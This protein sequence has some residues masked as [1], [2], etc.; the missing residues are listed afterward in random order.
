MFLQFSHEALA[1]AHH[2]SVSL[3]FRI[4]V[5][6]T[7]TTTDRKASQDVF[8][9]LF[10]AEEFQNPLVNCWVETKSAFVRTDSRVEL[11][12]VT[13]VYLNLSITVNPRNTEANHAFWLSNASQNIFFDV[14][15]MFFKYRFQSAKELFNSLKEFRFMAVASFYGFESALDIFF[16][17]CHVN[18]PL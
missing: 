4:E 2:F 18:S 13:T 10:E 3:A 7:F 17:S 11:N 14:F 8:E 15:W 6:S 12:T 9:D 5:R 1:E 16:C